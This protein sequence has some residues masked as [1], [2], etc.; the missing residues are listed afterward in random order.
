[1][2]K[3][4]N[5]FISMTLC[6]VL[7][8][9]SLL[10]SPVRAEE[11]EAKASA[12]PVGLE[13]WYDKP[14]T[15][16]N[17]VSSSTTSADDLQ[18]LT[19]GNGYMGAAFYG[20]L[21]NE[22]LQLS[23][24]T[25]WKSGPNSRADYDGGNKTGGN[26]LVPELREAAFE[27]DQKTVD[28]IMKTGLLYGKGL[29]YRGAYQTFGNLNL[30]FEGQPSNTPEDYRR[31]LNLEEATG[32][33]E[34]TYD[35]VTY[36]RE[37]FANYP[38]NVMAFKLSAS[39]EGKM[40]F[41]INL[42]P[43]TK[44]GIDGNG[45]GTGKETKVNV[46]KEIE[47]KDTL[48]VTA[49]VKSND[50]KVA[51]GL[52]VLNDG[53][54][55]IPT[56]DKDIRVKD[57][58]S[59]VILL[60]IGTD[61]KNEWPDYTGEDPLPA[62]RERIDAAAG[63]GY[64][65][66]RK[67]HIAD[68]EEIFGT[69]HVDFGQFDNKKPT[70][71]LLRD[72]QKGF[73]AGDLSDNKY[74][75]LEALTFQ[76]GRYA[77]I[78]SSRAG[79]LPANLQGVWND[80][81]NPMWSSDYHLNVN[82]EMNYWPAMNT[83]MADTMLPL[84]DYMESLREP[85]RVTAREYLG[86]EDGGWT[87][88]CSNNPFGY[89]SPHDTYNYA[90]N[91]A[92]SAWLSAN[93][94][95]YYLFTG[96]EEMLREHIYPIM[97]EAA[98]ALSK[99]L[100]ED[101]RDGTLVIAPSFSSEHGPVTVGTTYEQSLTYQLFEN[102][103]ESSRIV[104][105][106][107][108]EF[109]NT[110][111]KQKER[112]DPIRIGEWGQIKEWR[113][114]DIVEIGDLMNSADSG[115]NHRHNSHLLGLYPLFMVTPETPDEFAAAKVSME[116]R[117]NDNTGWSRAHKMNLWARLLD[118]T[119]AM[120]CYSG[121]LAERTI[122][123]LFD[124]HPPFQIDGTLGLTAGVGEMLLQS[125]AG[126]VQP[127]PALPK[128]WKTGSF[129][130]LAARGNFEV[131]AAWE[132]DAL[133]SMRVLSNKGNDLRLR[134]NGIAKAV[135]TDMQGK[136]VAFTVEDDNTI[137]FATDAGMTYTVT[138]SGKNPSAYQAAA[139]SAKEKPAPAK[140]ATI[141]QI[142]AG[143][144]EFGKSDRELP[145]SRAAL[146]GQDGADVRMY[147]DSGLG[148]LS[149]IAYQLPV[150]EK[151]AAVSV[152][153]RGTGEVI[154]QRLVDVAHYSGLK[155]DFS[156]AANLAGT[157]EVLMQ[158]EGSSEYVSRIFTVSEGGDV[159]DIASLT[160]EYDRTKGLLA[161]DYTDESWKT[162]QTAR[163]NALPVIEAGTTDSLRRMTVLREQ[164]AY[165]RE[166]LAPRN[167]TKTIAASDSSVAKEGN[168]SASGSKATSTANGDTL[169]IPFYGEGI[170]VLGRINQDCGKVEVY[171]DGALDKTVDLYCLE[172]GSDNAEIYK[173]RELPPGN[174]T[175]TLKHTGARNYATDNKV[176]INQFN[177]DAPA[178]GTLVT[179]ENLLLNKTVSATNTYKNNATYGPDKAVDGSSSTRWAT[180]DNVSPITMTFHLGQEETFNYLVIKEASGFT[181]RV[182]SFTVEANIGGV[183][184]E[185]GKGGGIGASLGVELPDTTAS[186]IRV[187]FTMSGAQGVTLSEVEL[188]NSYYDTHQA[189][190]QSVADAFVV[191]QPKKGADRI[192]NSV[193]PLGFDAVITGCD[194]EDVVSLDG[195]IT[196]PLQDTD[197]TLTYTITNQADGSTATKT[198]VVTV[199]AD[200]ALTVE[201]VADMLNVQQPTEN[202]TV[203]IPSVLPSGY[204]L[205]IVGTSDETVIDKSGAI[206]DHE[207]ETTV[208][209]TYRITKLA[210]NTT[211]ER[212]FTI[213]VP[214][215][216]AEAETEVIECDNPAIKY[217]TEV[218]P[219]SNGLAN[220]WFF[221]SNAADQGGK[222]TAYKWT[223]GEA[224]WFELTFE[225]EEVTILNRT[226]TDEYDYQITVYN[227]EGNEVA[228]GTAK[229]NDEKGNQKEVY[230]LTG[231]TPG[232]YTLRGES[233]LSEGG[234]Y[235]VLDGFIVS[236]K[237][238]S[239]STDADK[240]ALNAA[241]EKAAEIIKS[242]KLEKISYEH[243][244]MFMNAYNEMLVTRDDP[245]AAQEQVDSAAGEMMQV[246]SLLTDKTALAEALNEAGD[247]LS[248][249]ENY[250]PDAVDKLSGAMDAA[251]R[252]LEDENAFKDEIDKALK[253][254]VE[255]IEDMEL[256]K[257]D[258]VPLENLVTEGSKIMAEIEAGKYV[259][260]DML[261]VYI[262]LYK[263]AVE[264]LDNR[265]G[266]T[267]D[268][269][270]ELTNS[271]KDA[272][273][274]LQ[275]KEE[276]EPTESESSTEETE[277]TESES[278]TEETRP[279]EAETEEPSHVETNPVETD[280]TKPTH[281]ET[282][283][284]ETGGT[285]TDPSVTES[286]T[287]ETDPAETESSTEETEEPGESDAEVK[288]DKL[289]Q[290]IGK[291]EMLKAEDYTAE[292]FAKVEE[293]LNAAWKAMD[294][295]TQKE[296]DDAEKALNDAIE[297]LVPAS[298][299]SSMESSP[300]ESESTPG[301]GDATNFKWLAAVMV[302]ALAAAA[303][304]AIT[305]QIAG[306]KRRK[307][308]R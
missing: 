33:V 232:K 119:N 244:R 75:E 57:A 28:D 258:W 308:N 41:T 26:K 220:Q 116:D 179:G 135:V 143:F 175:L 63:K 293:A 87:V 297:D 5:K 152:V 16:K 263:K 250:N 55:L 277:P 141:Y 136:T 197:V 257:K 130:G 94:Y 13:M 8:L 43:F 67:E 276:T 1:M 199:K 253:T 68:Y 140:S 262:E 156:V 181:N 23:E 107:D 307:N 216:E 260:D 264:M 131:D 73:K 86:I 145:I 241:I 252:V 74:R 108:T 17:W 171:L 188:Y 231:L 18:P 122:S 64:E 40:N 166:H 124:V 104:G 274:K 282:D 81:N 49:N 133:T 65:E 178:K 144:Q 256:N 56:E 35:G 240:T 275:L 304:A 255:A 213:V 270:E 118:G 157:F 162:L 78:S 114:E 168:W 153:D 248:A 45:N 300:Q 80:N 70:N 42:E 233:I 288:T 69:V 229:C 279:T 91:P 134:Y 102:V 95:D 221:Q 298:A 137:F 112:L 37:Y 160:Q 21:Q 2:S 290:A 180:D 163:A 285:E 9:S 83:N 265:A 149:F 291:A 198:V 237:K 177:I 238:P 205:E 3:K 267:A 44:E 138:M 206:L 113:E 24:K 283:P 125:H 48:I 215:E 72:Y 54:E 99:L 147:Y 209:V 139:P 85:G 132:E 299:E 200:E 170:T 242:G 251:E 208:E 187:V 249:P 27:Y 10:Y 123:S 164:M 60:T 22:K 207:T 7:V 173:K 287:E 222:V 98:E 148:D 77:L 96:D 202:S 306:R 303:G 100:V 278:G 281:E 296:V 101:P 90:L 211:A 6:V 20:D 223:A 31:Y 305:M 97:K 185:I 169:T 183:W 268:E 159:F 272:A 167:Q 58:D 105:E 32:G 292:S 129:E 286:S 235:S 245:M 25:I 302:I 84:I 89:T 117:G 142:P 219:S 259:E 126:Y 225:G 161:R 195:T 210:D 59:V 295:K 289:E 88:N 111:A 19:I 271:L 190:A 239:E 12:S 121:I 214:A 280:P 62:V 76:F 146:E 165:A 106:S 217:S 38:S 155:A 184:K 228:A 261:A 176:V 53:G 29:I 36:T 186:E 212:T 30:K 4:G 230:K 172:S 61:Y 192:V 109:I 203:L 234:P 196:A 301:T 47:G 50:M 191:Y 11:A 79:S 82:L 46:K 189:T 247:R 15:R 243:K 224:P 115:K 71:E 294:A 266:A 194:N 269:V 110:L 154:A 227:E 236:G 150:K 14:A 226:G 151:T 182:A 284:V 51:S 120:E 218:A 66:L 204:L 128:E 201:A 158:F 52:R 174:H 127:I 254:L 103:I 92:S 246:L 34:Y 93:I 39:E 273:G 193:V